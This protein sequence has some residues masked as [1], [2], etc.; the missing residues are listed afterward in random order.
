MATKEMYDEDSYNCDTL[1]DLHIQNLVLFES[2]DFN[3]ISL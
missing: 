1:T 2:I 3:R